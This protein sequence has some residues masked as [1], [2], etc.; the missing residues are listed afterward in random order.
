MTVI[1]VVV[2]VWLLGNLAFVLLRYRATADRRR[3]V[4]AA[5]PALHAAGPTVGLP[6]ASTASP[7]CPAVSVPAQALPASIPAQRA[8]G[9]AGPPSVLPAQYGAGADDGAFSVPT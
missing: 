1:P 7:S 6:G 2:L 5:L 3:P 4:T 8:V 9:A